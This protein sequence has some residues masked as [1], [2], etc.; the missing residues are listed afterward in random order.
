[1]PETVTRKVNMKCKLC[2]L[3]QDDMICSMVLPTGNGIYKDLNLLALRMSSTA[4]HY[5]YQE[6]REQ[7]NSSK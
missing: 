1:M 5:R 7:F 3:N 2:C 4:F 6:K